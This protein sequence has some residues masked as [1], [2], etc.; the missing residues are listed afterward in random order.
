MAQRTMNKLI[1]DA[2]R[3]NDKDFQTKL[4]ARFA[5]YKAVQQPESPG[6][7]PVGQ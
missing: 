7:P 3:G 2:K 1:D 6:M 4:E 5:P